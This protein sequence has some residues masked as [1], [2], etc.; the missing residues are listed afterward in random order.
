MQPLTF[1]TLKQN[2]AV[3]DAYTGKAATVMDA[4][5]NAAAFLALAGAD[6]EALTPLEIA[7]QAAALFKATFLR[8]E[9]NAPEGTA[10][11]ST[12]AN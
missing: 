4:T 12:G 8:P 9:E 7:D 5:E 10:E 6:T 1:G 11:P 3:V 2:R